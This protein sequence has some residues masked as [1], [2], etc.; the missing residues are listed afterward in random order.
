MGLL[1]WNLKKADRMAHINEQ[2]LPL[3]LIPAPSKKET[4]EIKKKG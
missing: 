3:S 4:D 2:R 1:N